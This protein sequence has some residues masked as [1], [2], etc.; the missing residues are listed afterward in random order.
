MPYRVGHF[1]YPLLGQQRLDF[2][3]RYYVPFL[4]RLD[5]K[6]LAGVAILGQNNFAEVTPSEDREQS[7]VLEAHA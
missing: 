7:E 2:V 6:V 1:E 3:P 4:Q 5:G